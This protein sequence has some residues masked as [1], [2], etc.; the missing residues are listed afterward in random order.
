MTLLLLRLLTIAG[1]VVCGTTAAI[2]ADEMTFSR[3][4][5]PILSDRCF[6]CHGPEATHR[7]ADLRLDLRESA[8]ADRGGYAVISPG[9]P[10]ASALLT[11]IASDDPDL[12]MPPPDAHRKPLTPAERQALRQWIAAGA[13]WGRHWAFEKPVRPPALVAKPTENEARP[14]VH[15]IDLLV[16]KRLLKEGLAPA[17][18]AERRTLIRRLSFDLTGLPPTVAQVN[19]FL[20]DDSP[21]AYGRL[22]DRLLESPHYGERMAMWWLDAARYSDTDGFQGDALRT[23]WPWRDWVVQAFNRNMPYDQFTLEQFAGDLL[24]DAAPEQIL[25]T[26]FHRNHMTNGEGGRDPEESRIDYVMDRVNTTGAVW[27]GLTLGCAQCHSHKFDPI[28]QQDYYSLFAFFNSIDEDGKAGNKAKPYLPF[29]SPA[30][31]RAVTETEQLVERRQA[32][33]AAARR[34]A[35]H[36]FEPW[37]AAQIE[38]VQ[39]GFQPWR[40][41]QARL[42]EATEGTLLTQQADG[43]IQA[44]GPHPRQDDYRLTSPVDP[45]G[46]RR[47]TGWRL[48]V[49]PHASHTDG[50]LS[51]GASGEFILTDVKLQVQRQGDSQVRDIELAAAVADVEKKVSGRN[52]GLIKDTLDDDPRNG[53]TTES[54]DALTPHRAVFALAE[55]LILAPDEELIFLLLQR[56]TVGDANLGR[57]RISLSDQPGPAVR[58]LQPMPLEELAAWRAEQE[59]S[60]KEPSLTAVPQA[61]RQRLLAQFLA[62]H[63][64]DQ[65]AQAA[66][67]RAENQLA[68]LRKADKELNV[69]VLGERPEPRPSFVLERGIWDK[70]G[71]AVQPAVPA[72]VLDWPAEKTATRMDL[73][74][75]LMSPDHPLTARVTVN[76]LWQLCFGAGLVRTPEDFGLQGEPPTHPDLLDALAVELVE[77]DWDLKHLLRVIVTSD[78]YRQSS[79]VTPELQE[80]DPENRWLA[81]GARFRLPSWMIR[82]AALQASGLINPALGGPPVAPYQP[83]GVWEEMFMGRLQYEPSQGPAQFRRTLYAFWRRS[84][85]PTFLFDSAQ[86]RVCEVGVRRTNT[87]LQALTLLNDQSV[88]E[89]SRELA[90]QAIAAEKKPAA[91]LQRLAQAILSRP[92]TDAEMV[93]LQREQERAQTYYN[94]APADAATLLDFGQSPHQAAA[95]EPDLAALMVVASLLFNLDEAITHE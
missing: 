90:R 85:A 40:P 79:R 82:D 95:R 59:T 19:A 48:E 66:L 31:A 43:V 62:D 1:L 38:H 86:R 71:A 29:H 20:A 75:W 25:A 77:H 65:L 80:R 36:E 73:A 57:F 28:S 6:H 56:S 72:A 22:V 93:V 16:R 15:P 13:P 58:S 12:Q 10:E 81:R 87:P 55:P 63:Q 54:H 18:P 50:K 5:L 94:R 78:T 26:C 23:N 27:L 76:H 44:S 74:R 53:W 70:H 49:F 2:R 24:P 33:A 4:V 32:T 9:K 34:L 45:A 47:V 37:L 39:G 30:A 84:A 60:T 42:L 67:D 52:Y 83:P 64:G 92:A 7:E 46:P 14:A 35:E 17:P 68:E 51:R 61:L 3:D 91:R 41:V 89:A 88:L 69:M 11:R 21:Q 8:L